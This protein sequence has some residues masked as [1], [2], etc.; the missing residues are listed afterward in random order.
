[1]NRLNVSICDKKREG[2]EVKDASTRWS[3]WRTNPVYSWTEWVKRQCDKWLNHKCEF[4]T[5]LPRFLLSHCIYIYPSTYGLA[6][7]TCPSQQI[8]DSLFLCREHWFVCLSQPTFSPGWSVKWLP[9]CVV[10]PG[11]LRCPEETIKW[12]SCFRAPGLSTG[13]VM[14]SALGFFLFSV[15]LRRLAVERCFSVLCSQ[16]FTETTVCV[17]VCV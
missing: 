2:K 15:G 16:D 8:Y 14:M 13:V 12:L 6:V 7:L 3:F 5:C 4:H 11:L 9:R 10:Q 17:C 1:M